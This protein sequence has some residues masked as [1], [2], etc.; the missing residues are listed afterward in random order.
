VL[1]YAFG[2]TRVKFWEYVFWSCLCT[3][4]STVFFV[5][6]ARAVLRGAREHQ[7]PWTLVGVLGGLT[8]LLALVMAWVEKRLERRS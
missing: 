1:N 2:L 8:L 3:L 4:P 6:S 7:V 5:I